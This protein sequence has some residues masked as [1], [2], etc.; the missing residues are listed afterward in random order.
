LSRTQTVAERLK[1]QV[2]LVIVGQ[3]AVIEQAILAALASGHVLLEGVPGTAKTLLVKVL[4][5]SLGC[6]FQR[7]QLTP[8]LMPADIV[9]V[10]IYNPNRGEFEFRQGPI[11]A[12]FLLADEIN[13][14]PAKTQ[15]ALLEGMEER[16]VTVD[17]RTHLLPEPFIV[18]ATQN[19]IEHEGTYALP[20]A[21]LDRFLFQT[22]VDYPPRPAEYA[23]LRMHDGG[24][25]PHNLE[26]LGLQ[27]AAS[28]ED[29]AAC[30]AE[31]TSIRVE[32]AVLG[33]VLDIIRLTRE[34]PFL[35]LGASPRAAAMLLLASK[36]LAAVRGREF[37]IP[38]DV[39]EMAKPVLRH[40]VLLQPE[41]EIDGMSRDQAVEAVVA[42]LKVPR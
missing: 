16:R 9:G 32:D 18:F 26:A 23:M 36:G 1:R 29:L 12:Q 35:L 11:F 40:R 4:A 7:V 5:T 24:F 22:I 14:T 41:A 3:D 30:R 28:T 34:S 2:G 38:D 25:N 15:A 21:Q 33:Y 13:R 42:A 19:P 6:S 17:G 20:E 27:V 37:V 8:D 39:K 31:I 10:N